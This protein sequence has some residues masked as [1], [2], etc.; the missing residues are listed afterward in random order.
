MVFIAL[1][2]VHDNKELQEAPW[3]FLKKKNCIYYIEKNIILQ[4]IGY[5]NSKFRYIFIQNEE[6]IEINDI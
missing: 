4:H 2:K 1:E 3:K 5:H 6:D